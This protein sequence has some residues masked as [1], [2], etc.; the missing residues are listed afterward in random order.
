MKT[1]SFYLTPIILSLGLSNI[2]V[3]AAESDENSQKR[4]DSLPFSLEG[5]PQ[6]GPDP[7]IEYKGK[8]IDGITHVFYPS[9]R[10]QRRGKRIDDNGNPDINGKGD[11][12]FEI[13]SEEDCYLT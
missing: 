1:L 10:L 11:G 6:T 5:I 7:N 3:V 2:S 4:C 12:A 13:F 9:G 8:L